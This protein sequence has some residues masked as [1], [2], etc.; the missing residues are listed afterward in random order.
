MIVVGLQIG[1]GVMIVLAW[2]VAA[3]AATASTAAALLT[4]ERVIVIR[5][6][7]ALVF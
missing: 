7:D 1:R 5:L 6:S 2:I 4:F 3:A